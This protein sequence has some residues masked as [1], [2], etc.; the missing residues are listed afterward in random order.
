MIQLHKLTFTQFFI[1]E[2]NVPLV[3]TVVIQNFWQKRQGNLHP[4]IFLDFSE[5]WLLDYDSYINL[6]VRFS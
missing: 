2:I 5:T 1:V 3:Y 6:N 4:G